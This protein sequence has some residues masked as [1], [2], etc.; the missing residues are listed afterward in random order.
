MNLQELYNKQ[1]NPKLNLYI[2]ET[3]NNRYEI[4][5]KENYWFKYFKK[6]KLKNL[7]LNKH[8]K[9]STGLN[10]CKTSNKKTCYICSM[11]NLTNNNQYWSVYPKLEYFEHKNIEKLSLKSHPNK[12][13]QYDFD[14]SDISNFTFSIIKETNTSNNWKDFYLSRIEL[15]TDQD[16]TKPPI[17]RNIILSNKK[18]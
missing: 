11:K 1:S 15:L 3:T 7:L 13:L 12:H 10:P 9:G 8:L 6:Q 14:Q 5:F 2:L 18:F 17:P 4:S 16:Y